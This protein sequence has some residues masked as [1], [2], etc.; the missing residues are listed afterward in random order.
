[1]QNNFMGKNIIFFPQGKEYHICSPIVTSC[2]KNMQDLFGEK[3]VIFFPQGKEYHIF[4]EGVKNIPP[5][6]IIVLSCFPP[7]TVT[8]HS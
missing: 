1:M 7:F 8:V 2:Q 6:P 5:P 4:P 3:N